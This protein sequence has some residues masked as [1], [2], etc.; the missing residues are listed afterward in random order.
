MRRKIRQ[1]SLLVCL[2]CFASSSLQQAAYATVISPEAYL[3]A[4]ERGATLA[5]IDAVLAREDVARQLTQLGVS[6]S[7]AIER[8]AALSDAELLELA[9]HLDQLPAGGSALGVIGIVFIVL[10]ILELVGVIDIFNR[11]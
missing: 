7:D 5:R 4:S 2:V 11:I 6:A 9:E 10:L 1:W 3:N 8:A